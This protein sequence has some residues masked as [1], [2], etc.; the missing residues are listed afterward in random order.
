MVRYRIK[1]E[2]GNVHILELD[3]VA[4]NAPLGALR[5]AWEKGRPWDARE[6]HGTAW[7]LDESRP[8]YINP[9]A[10]ATIQKIEGETS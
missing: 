7:P 4:E 9:S 2:T 1:M 5:L 8:T 10:V 6:Y 3:G